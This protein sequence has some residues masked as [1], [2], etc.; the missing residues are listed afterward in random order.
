MFHKQ[1]PSWGELL[2]Q[3]LS[4]TTSG[5]DLLAEKFDYTPFCTPN[6]LLEPMVA[7]LKEDPRPA[8]RALDLCCGTGAAMRALRQV[9]SHEVHGVD[10]SAGMLDKARRLLEAQDA[11]TTQRD[12][13][14]PTFELIQHDAL[15]FEPEAPFDLVTCFGAFGHILAP[16]QDRFAETVRRALHPGGRFVF[17][18]HLMP[19]VGSRSWLISRG[20]N[21]AMHVRNA[22]LPEEFVMFYLT[23]PL[24]RAVDVLSRHGFSLKVSA[25]Y[26]RFD[27]GDRMRLVVATTPE[28]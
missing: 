2:R 4:D 23:F 11:S 1:G 16:D 18:T 25:P 8:R 28:A 15:T 19:P 13:P 10:L 24:E 3:A 7:S 26:Q 20:F 22:L 27:H 9:V 21:A 5:Y 17:V 12:A 14:L 6:E